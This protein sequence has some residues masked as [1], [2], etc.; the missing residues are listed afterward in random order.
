[1]WREAGVIGRRFQLLLDLLPS[2]PWLWGFLLSILLSLTRRIKW[3]LTIYDGQLR[4]RSSTRRIMCKCPYPPRRR[5][6]TRS[7]E[8]GLM[9]LRYLY[10]NLP[11][12]FWLCNSQF[13]SRL[14]GFFVGSL[15]CKYSCHIPVTSFFAMNAGCTSY[16]YCL[17]QVIGLLTAVVKLY[18]WQLENQPFWS[19]QVTCIQLTPIN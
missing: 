4:W 5:K 7:A 1:M 8:H 17:R 3:L 15:V 10:F 16:S 19:Q 13:V 11:K 6:S 12:H 9:L 14:E 2:P 18:Q